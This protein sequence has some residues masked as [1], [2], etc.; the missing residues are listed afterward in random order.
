MSFDWL[1]ID[2][3]NLKIEA[4]IMLKN[5]IFISFFFIFHN[6]Y[7]SD[8]STKQNIDENKTITLH[9]TSDN[10]LPYNRNV[11]FITYDTFTESVLGLL[12]EPT[13]SFL[14]SFKEGVA[15]LSYAEPLD[16][17]SVIHLKLKKNLY[18]DDG[19]DRWEATS[20]DLRFSLARF[21]FSKINTNYRN[22]LSNIEGVEKIQPGTKYDP[23][24]IPGIKIINKYEVSIKLK[25]IDPLFVEH[26]SHVG[27]PLVSMKTLTDNYLDWKNVPVGVGAYK[28]IYANNVTGETILQKRT[29]SHYPN[30]Q[31]YIRFL[32]SKD[33][34][35]DIFWKDMWNLDPKQYKQE[36]LK[37][38]YGT[39]AIF[40]NYENKLGNNENFRKAISLAINR[41][42]LV[43]GF[44]YLKKNSE[45]IA[46]DTWGR[47]DLDKKQ[48]IELAKKYLS[49]V[50]KELIKDK[51]EVFLSGQNQYA[52]S[53][54]YFTK[55]K[56]QLESIGLKLIFKLDD[57]NVKVDSCMNI[58][59]IGATYKDPAYIFGY[60]RKGSWY[61]KNYPKNDAYIE[62]EFSKLMNATTIE[63]KSEISKNLSTYLTENAIVVPLWD[64][65]TFY[66]YNTKKITAQSF[67][68]QPGGLRF[69]VWEVKKIN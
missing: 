6:V 50:P 69:K 62:S 21:F 35:G 36:T 10:S 1:H 51:I 37:I 38:T 24:L 30:A 19:V 3:S 47:S 2:N 53:K 11:P 61:H 66:T 13:N 54:P 52:L 7:A 32:S 15:V 40:F 63:S 4:F 23:D 42:E 55:L 18:F 48:N 22:L 39:L 44:S 68:I 64:L 12:A 65:Y 20:E 49:K 57:S 60:F 25:T 56:Q 9:F 14:P 5:L 29:D 26:I 46:V 8:F 27:T 28:I 16:E 59:G 17:P 45:I 43:K 34:E 31:K 67:Y 58:T 33:D 41:D